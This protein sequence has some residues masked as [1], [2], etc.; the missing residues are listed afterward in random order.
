MR[1]HFIK[2]DQFSHEWQGI[3]AEKVKWYLSWNFQ[4]EL[5]FYSEESE[6]TAWYSV[7]D[8][9]SKVYKAQRWGLGLTHRES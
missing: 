2:R 5:G 7:P 8:R 1:K 3:K 4:D 9:K 6:E